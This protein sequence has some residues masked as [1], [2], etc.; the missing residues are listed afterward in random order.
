MQSN[1][2]LKFKMCYNILVEKL[3]GGGGGAGMCLVQK[4]Q[5]NGKAEIV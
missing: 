2:E 3:G 5:Q 1:L 4:M